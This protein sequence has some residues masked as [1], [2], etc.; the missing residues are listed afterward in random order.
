MIS[1]CELYTFL[2]E[3][4]SSMAVNLLKWVHWNAY[5]S[6]TARTNDTF[7]KR[8]IRLFASILRVFV[9]ITLVG[10]IQ[11]H[12]FPMF[13]VSE[14]S[15]QFLVQRIYRKGRLLFQKVLART[16]YSRK[17]IECNEF[18]VATASAR[19]KKKKQRQIH[20]QRLKCLIFVIKCLHR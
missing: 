11:R 5:I 17:Q 14:F 7:W 4:N 13:F 6:K 19:N 16:F 12:V 15:N 2:N 8:F 10:L 9:C 3:T 18:K 20:P 1:F